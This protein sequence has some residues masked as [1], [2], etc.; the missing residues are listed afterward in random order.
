M[1]LYAK[2]NCEKEW[3][4][5]MALRN[6]PYL[7]LYVQDFMTDEKL[8]ECS[9]SANGVYIRLMCIMHKSENYGQILLKQKYKQNENKFD[10]LLK[11]K[12]KQTDKQILFFAYQ[13]QKNM[14]FSIEEIASGL[15]ELLREKVVQ[16][17]NDVLFQKRMVKDGMLSDKRASAGSKGGKQSILLKQNQEICSSKNLSK[18]KANSE[19]EI[20]YENENENINI[21]INEKEKISKEIRRIDPYCSA[22]ISEFKKTYEKVFGNSPFL[23]NEDCCNFSEIVSMTAD[24]FETLESCLSKVKQIDFEK[25]GYNPG[26]GWFL[27]PKNYAD[28]RNGV[29][30]SKLKAKAVEGA[31]NDGFSY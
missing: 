26:A 1:P 23:T 29:Y 10:D 27:K 3:G 5:K 19:N 13:L 6:Q 8:N 4:L 24:F 7:P 9:A 11:Q 30:D 21:S 28:L 25:I 31:K 14:P 2:N 12:F 22:E 17:E 16:I 20:E 18:I 15:E